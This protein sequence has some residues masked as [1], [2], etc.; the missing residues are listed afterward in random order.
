M[1]NRQ[2]IFTLTLIT[3]SVLF[4]AIVFVGSRDRQQQ[5]QQQNDQE[6]QATLTGINYFYGVTCPFCDQVS[7]WMEENQVESILEI[8]KLEVYQDQN[9]AAL[10][11][12]AAQACGLNTGSIGVPFLFSEGECL[13]GKPDIIAYLAQEA[14][15]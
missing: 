7:D 6:V 10:L 12:S 13:I 3:V 5:T 4:L 1:F 11:R 15:I 9:N 14:G 8:N 2:T